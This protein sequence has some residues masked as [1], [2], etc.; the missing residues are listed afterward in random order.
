[1]LLRL[2]LSI[3]E[4]MFT[5]EEIMETALENFDLKGKKV[6]VA[7]GG[8]RSV[9]T[10]IDLEPEM[11][12]CACVPGDTGRLNRIFNELG[13]QRR[14]AEVL[15]INLSEP[16]VF[17]SG[18]FDFILMD[19]LVSKVDMFAPRKHIDILQNL[20]EYLKSQ[21][22]LVVVDIEPD[23]PPAHELVSYTGMIE[24]LVNVEK[25]LS[26]EL[27][28]PARYRFYER[29]R[30]LIADLALNHGVPGFKCIPGDWVEQWLIG[31][32]FEDVTPQIASRLVSAEVN[33]EYEKQTRSFVDLITD[34][35][36]RKYVVALMDRTEALMREV[37]PYEFEQDVYI[38]SAV[39]K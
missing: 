21:G 25:N 35:K 3:I 19:Y 15:S 29:I 28:D 18:S 9:R 6:L 7:G 23:S 14:D 36:I 5:K 27:D 2:K 22:N 38:I 20:H 39:K 37:S 1:M 24:S 16:N 31:I 10:V 32:G 12:I 11:L 4:A 13:G 26:L 34:E 8:R 30:K 17:E 33:D